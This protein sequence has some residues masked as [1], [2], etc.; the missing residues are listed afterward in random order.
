MVVLAAASQLDVFLVVA[1][2][3]QA[4]VVSWVGVESRKAR[5][6]RKLRRVHGDKP[7][8]DPTK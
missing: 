3:I 4:L 1:N 6:E 5:A 2:I 7:P 8:C